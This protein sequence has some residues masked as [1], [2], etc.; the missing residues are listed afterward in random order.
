MPAKK[1]I[2]KVK[3]AGA[4]FPY[5][6][7]KARKFIDSIDKKNNR[8]ILFDKDSDGI[9][10]A[11]LIIKYLQSK[12]LEPSFAHSKDETGI[13]ISESLLNQ[14][15]DLDVLITCDLPLDQSG[16]V[17]AL[18]V[19]RALVIDHHVPVANLTKNGWLHINPRFEDANTYR[20][21]SYLTYVLTQPFSSR[22]SWIAGIGVLSDYGLK[23]CS[24]LVTEIAKVHPELV[25]K[26][27]LDQKAMWKSGLG[28][29]SGIIAAAYGT[30]SSKGSD[31]A[32]DTVVKAENPEDVTSSRLMLHYN[33][34]QGELEHVMDDF[35]HNAEHHEKFGAYVYRVSSKYK[36][37]SVV[38]TLVSERYADNVVFLYRET[39][40]HIECSVRCQSGRVDVA[41]LMQELTRGIGSGG[42]HQKAAGGEVAIEHRDEFL[43]R[44]RRKFEGL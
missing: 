19:K 25:T 21:T 39:A 22:Y 27:P 37:M 6:L 2:K 34:F 26:N 20:P 28:L 32:F 9:C 5:G 38:A 24:D 11:T 36:I 35:E 13:N 29:L 10:S 44:M 4:M 42:G 17:N 40:N 15:N 3:N 18:N 31:E 1:T 30:E 12:G 7:D 43:E 23:D 16:F 14:I 8:G 33:K 41:A